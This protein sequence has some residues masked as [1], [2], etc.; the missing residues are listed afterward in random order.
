MNDF[1][2]TASPQAEH[3]ERLH[4]IQILGEPYTFWTDTGVFSKEGLDDGTRIL[5]ESLPEL[6][7]RVLDLGCGWGPIGISLAKKNP[8]AELLLTDINERAVALAKKNITE[9]RISNATVFCGDGL[10]AVTGQFDA[11]VTNPPIRT[12]KAVLYPLFA[13]CMDRLTP[14]GAFYMVIRKQQGAPSAVKYLETIA[15]QVERIAREKSYWV[16]RCRKE[17]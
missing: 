6:S 13:Q 3:D 16:L 2:Y 5:L 9:N 4:V 12:G 8:Q 7:G 10:E 1:Y 11:I 15:T 17:T 14:N